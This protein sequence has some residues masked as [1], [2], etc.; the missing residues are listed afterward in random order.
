MLGYFLA[1]LLLSVLYIGFA[2]VSP[3]MVASL[4]TGKGLHHRWVDIEQVPSTVLRAVVASEDARFCD[5]HG[6]DVQAVNKAVKLAERTGRAPRG[7]STVTMQTAKNLF[8]WNTRSWIRKAIEAPIALW[9]DTIW[10]KKR[11][12]EVYLNIAQWGDGVF[13]IEEAARRN[14]GVNASGLSSYQAALLVTMLPDPERR[15]A[16]NPGPK[17]R[18][19]AGTVSARMWDA[20]ISCVRH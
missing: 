14:F 8:L 19:M 7:A 1:V 15:S 17:M 16:R 9:L 13:G 20:D 18:S 11:I 12:L 3:L 6:I 4:V 2:P 10:T 5:H